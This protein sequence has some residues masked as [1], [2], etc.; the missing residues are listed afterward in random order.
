MFFSFFNLRVMVGTLHGGIDENAVLLD[1][2]GI[3]YKTLGNNCSKQTTTSKRQ[4]DRRTGTLTC[5]RAISQEAYCTKYLVIM[6]RNKQ[7][8]VFAIDRQTEK[9]VH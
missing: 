9:Q 1:T 3:L 4:T 8:Q 2:V 7:P 5:N 6:A